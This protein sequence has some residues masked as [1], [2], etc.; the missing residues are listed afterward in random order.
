MAAIS[1]LEFAIRYIDETEADSPAA[2]EV[3]AVNLLYGAGYTLAQNGFN[4]QT[5][6]S[7]D[8][9]VIETITLD[10]EGTTTDLLA[11]RLATLTDE[12]RNVQRMAADPTSP[13]GAWLRRKLK[14]ETNPLQAII[15]DMRVDTRQHIFTPATERGNYVIDV[16]ITLTRGPWEAT[17]SMATITLPNLSSFCGAGN[18]YSILGD[19]PA[20][21]VKAL[22][23]SGQ[24]PSPTMGQLWAGIKAKEDLDLSKFLPVWELELGVMGTDTSVVADGNAS[25]G[26]VARCTFA[27]VSGLSERVAITNAMACGYDTTKYVHQ[28]GN[29]V[30]LLR[31]KGGTSTSY[32]FRLDHGSRIPG[33]VEYITGNLVE[34][35][36]DSSSAYYVVNLGVARIP[37]VERGYMALNRGQFAFRM[38]AE[39]VSGS[40]NLDMDCLG[41]I[42]LPPQN[43]FGGFFYACFFSTGDDGFYFRH[44]ADD[45]KSVTTR[46]Y[47]LHAD[48]EMLGGIPPGDSQMVACMTSETGVSLLT[49]HTDVTISAAFARYAS[50]VL[51]GAA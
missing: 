11:S 2:A 1:I 21:V 41:L 29:Y 34:Q 23:R 8:E 10:V 13:F 35:S 26:N 50:R 20:R 37:H 3:S 9:R 24:P 28:R 49:E 31:F 36:T 44:Y 43:T 27:T 16:V 47:S 38:M 14:D 46:Q 15:H 17:A 30:V 33:I 39:R 22:F 48:S 7:E 45:A 51:R 12:L 42:P 40:G 5:A 25:G 4:P 18:I 32:R 6:T 19:A